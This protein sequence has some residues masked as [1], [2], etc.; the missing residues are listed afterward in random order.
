M[1]NTNVPQDKRKLKLRRRRREIER[2]IERWTAAKE[3][4]LEKKAHDLRR[5]MRYAR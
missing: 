2:Q 5:D 3:P 4:D 1:A